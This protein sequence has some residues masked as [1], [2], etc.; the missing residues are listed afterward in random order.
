MAS[1]ISRFLAELKR[2]KGTRV[3]V[4]YALVG[5]AVIEGMVA[6]VDSMRARVERGEVDLGIR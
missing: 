3:A 5:I 2:R 1:K 6:D 4:A